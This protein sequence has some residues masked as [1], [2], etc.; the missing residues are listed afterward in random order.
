MEIFINTTVLITSIWL[1]TSSQIM[2]T[3]NFKSK[4]VFNIIPLI[5]GLALLFSGLKLV[6]WI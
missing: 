6:N 5:L 4:L 3:K 1:L 2:E